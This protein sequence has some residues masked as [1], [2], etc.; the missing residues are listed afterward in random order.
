MLCLVNPNTAFYR[1][2]IDF[3][4]QKCDEF[5]SIQGVGLDPENHISTLTNSLT[6]LQTYITLYRAY[7]FYMT[8]YPLNIYYIRFLM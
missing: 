6:N 4:N 2:F 8:L 7:V 5:D 1:V 3:F